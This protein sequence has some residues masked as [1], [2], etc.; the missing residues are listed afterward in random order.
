[1]RKDHAQ[2]YVGRC[3]EAVVPGYTAGHR[4][5]C[6]ICATRCAARKLAKVPVNAVAKA[7]KVALLLNEGN[8]I[9]V[10]V[11]FERWETHLEEVRLGERR[12]VA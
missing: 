9:F 1:M 7:V 11:S 2:H 10:K 3:R 6:K 4:V 5:A 12:E 8:V